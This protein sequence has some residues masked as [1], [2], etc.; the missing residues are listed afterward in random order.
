MG[1]TERRGLKV[2][3]HDGGVDVAI[4]RRIADGDGQVAEVE[5]DV[6]V[7]GNSL[8]GKVTGR[9]ANQEHSGT[10]DFDGHFKVVLGTAKDAQVPIIV[11]APEA[12]GEVASVVGI[13]A[14]KVD[15]YPIVVAA[16][17]PEFAGAEVQVQIAAGREVY[18][19]RMIL[20]VFDLD[21][22]IRQGRRY[23]KGE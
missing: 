16:D 23:Q 1:F 18:R 5:F 3:G 15:C 9:H 17:D 13:T 8:D 21:F 11:R 10:G 6:F 12:N 20:K 22:G 4:V 7:A 19:K 2:A 14:V